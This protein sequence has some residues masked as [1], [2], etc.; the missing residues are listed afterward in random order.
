MQLC[1]FEG[2]THDEA[3][4]RLAWPVGTVR[5]R[6]A[7][8][9]DRLRA[10]LTRRGLVVPAAVIS[11]ALD[12]SKAGAHVPSLLVK[13]TV[14][15]V[16]GRA[17]ASAIVS[18]ATH[19]LKEMF[20][21]QLRFAVLATLLT[22][23]CAF[24]ALPLSWAQVRPLGSPQAAAKNDSAP[25][26]EVG[27]VFFRVV[28]RETKQ[29]L[30]AVKLKVWING[31]VESEQAT[32]ETGRIVIR[33]PS[34][35]PESLSVAANRDGFT[36]INVYLRHRFAKETEIPRSY[37]LAMDR[38]TSIGGVVRDEEGRPIEGVS[39][40]LLANNPDD[41]GREV[42]D[43]RSMMARTDRQGR[44]HVDLIPAGLDLERLHFTSRI[45]NS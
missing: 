15:T 29:P 38:G 9:R 26:R 6:L 34:E 13:A 20:M 35:E 17:G 25:V 14:E 36:P 43:F 23:A 18:L 45:R 19:V 24:W 16:T 40:S 8:A 12:S 33:L 42:F 31:K 2:Q 11:A 44:W 30:P 4:Q 22:G 39:V 10:R 5:S 1:Y 37:T 32:D 41:S 7:G 3:A 28:D 21:G 27:M